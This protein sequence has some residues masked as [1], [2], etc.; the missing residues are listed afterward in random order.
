M[1]KLIYWLTFWKDRVPHDIR[2]GQNDPF[3]HPQIAS[4]DLQMLADLPPEQLRDRESARSQPT[5][6]SSRNPKLCT[7]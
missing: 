3:C 6:T 2:R 5:M 1:I 7:S 4:M